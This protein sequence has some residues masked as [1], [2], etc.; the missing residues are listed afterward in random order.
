[1]PKI[2]KKELEQKMPTVADKL[3]SGHPMVHTI[4]FPIDG[5]YKF[6]V[7]QAKDWL[8]NHNYK[9]GKMRTTTG[10][11]RFNQ[12]PSIEG[13]QYYTIILKNGVQLVIEKLV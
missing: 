11:M 5:K 4:L 7:Q 1:M 12:I 9:Y 3:E 6:E 8:K 13:G 2:T 10:F